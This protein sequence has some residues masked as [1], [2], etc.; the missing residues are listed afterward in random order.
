MWMI[1]E[2][3][4]AAKLNDFGE[5]PGDLVRELDPYADALTLIIERIFRV[6]E[7]SHGTIQAV[8]CRS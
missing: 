1:L 4:H 2:D 5:T 7:F 8:C 3:T 6:S